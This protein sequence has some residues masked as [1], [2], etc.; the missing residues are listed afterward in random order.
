MVK[1]PGRL[2]GRNDIF[3]LLGLTVALFVISRVRS[4]D[5]STTPAR[6]KKLGTA[7]PP[8]PGHPGR[9]LRV[10][11]VRKRHQLHAPALA[12]A[13]TAKTG[14]RERVMERLVNFGKALGESLDHA[15]IGKAAAEHL[16]DL[17]EGLGVWAMAV[18]DSA[19]RPL[20]VVADR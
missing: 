18:S 7:A 4:R 3:L 19:W 15:A 10:S 6:S 1:H 9:G 11:P 13:A 5:S 14:A 16:P 20:A 2:I 12:S 17:A 8:R